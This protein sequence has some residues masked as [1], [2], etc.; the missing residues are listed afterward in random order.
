MEESQNDK[1]HEI[2]LQVMRFPDHYQGMA[3]EML[4]MGASIEDVELEI[5]KY[6]HMY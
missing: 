6:N 1:E 4:L 2:S 5:E 3:K